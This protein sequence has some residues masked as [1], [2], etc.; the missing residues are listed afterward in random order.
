VVKLGGSLLADNNLLDKIVTQLIE[1]RNHH[2]EVI[3]V[4]GGG[5]QIKK[6]LERLD[7]ARRAG[8]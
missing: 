4:H 7:G 8:Q 5:K 2:H 3:V 6:Y 1:V